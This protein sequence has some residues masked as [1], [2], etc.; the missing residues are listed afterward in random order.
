M[1]K[2]LATLLRV[3]PLAVVAPFAVLMPFAVVSR[4]ANHD[5]SNGQHI[6]KVS[7]G[8]GVAGIIPYH[9]DVIHGCDDFDFNDVSSSR[10][11][12][13]VGSAPLSYV[14]WRPE[15]HGIISIPVGTTTSINELIGS[16]V[17]ANASAG[18]S[19]TDKCIARFVVSCDA[20]FTGTGGFDGEWY[21]GIGNPDGTGNVYAGAM[22]SF[23]PGFPEHPSSQLLAGSYTS[24]TSRTE[25]PTNFT[26]SP[27]TWYDLIISWTP[28]VIKYYAA[29][30]G[31]TPT[32]IAT[33]TTNIS[34]D[35]QYL[36]IGNCRYHKGSPAVN[37]LVEKVEWLYK[38]PQSGSFLQENLIKF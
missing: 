19:G 27:N 31:Q 24:Q 8:E 23:A 1:R 32:L 21:V 37:L 35:A 11:W 38:A 12:K 20:L 25:T 2:I 5:S 36:L 13:Y 34:T 7:V 17:C 15:H 3:R 22:L 29:V 4:L 28:G 9:S 14:P 6:L 30:Y 26:I 10:K 33:N 18:F 16:Q